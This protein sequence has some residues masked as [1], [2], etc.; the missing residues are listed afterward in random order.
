LFLVEDLLKIAS[1]LNSR[2]DEKNEYRLRVACF[3]RLY[4]DLKMRFAEILRE[5][6][7]LS[8]QQLLRRSF[9]FDSQSSGANDRLNK[10]LSKSDGDDKSESLLIEES[11]R[12]LNDPTHIRV[13]LEILESSRNWLTTIGDF[14]YLEIKNLLRSNKIINERTKNLAQSRVSMFSALERGA[15]VGRCLVFIVG[16]M[17]IC[18][19]IC[20]VIYHFLI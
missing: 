18:G 20:F 17:L 4:D 6:M 19:T 10:H 1:I 9:S 13:V 8:E 3:E 7:L 5:I 11:E 12:I 2:G 16:S 15:S 14:E